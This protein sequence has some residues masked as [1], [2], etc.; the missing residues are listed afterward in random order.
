MIYRI[1]MFTSKKTSILVA[2]LLISGCLRS[3]P[4]P[5]VIHDDNLL[6]A[7]IPQGFGFK[8]QLSIMT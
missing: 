7:K 3:C 4:H 6:D 1:R 2:M 5:T 8:D